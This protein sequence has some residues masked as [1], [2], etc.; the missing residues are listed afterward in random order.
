MT[1]DM[2]DLE[3]VQPVQSV[4]PGP[5]GPRYLRRLAGVGA[6]VAVT[7]AVWAIGRLAGADYVLRDP[8]GSVTIDVTTTAV[9]TLVVAGLGWAVLALLERFTRHA[10]GIWVGTAAVVVI[11]SMIPI[12]LVDATPATQVSLFF[13]HLAVVVLVPALLWARTT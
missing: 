8:A 3:T 10:V 11:V 7:A 13:V 12:F 4:P 2:N 9:V 1:N 6:T 5:G